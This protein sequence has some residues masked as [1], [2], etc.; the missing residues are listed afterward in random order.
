[1]EDKIIFRRSVALVGIAVLLFANVYL[2]FAQTTSVECLV[3][4]YD[5]PGGRKAGDIVSV[6]QLPHK[7]WG[8]EEGPPNYIIVKVTNISL[9][10]FNK[11]KG[12][13]VLVDEA[14]PDGKRVRS[15]YRFDLTALSGYSEISPK[16]EVN[17]SQI[18]ANVV[19]RRT[20]ALSIR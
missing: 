19:D 14:K 6:K 4:K 17:L 13:H 8:R 16:V 15:K 9:G 2:A 1:M 5:G 12:R 11:Y 3:R 7:G 10:A 18:I 20:E